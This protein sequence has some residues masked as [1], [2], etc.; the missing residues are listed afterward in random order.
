M[1]TNIRIRRAF[2][3]LIDYCNS[4]YYDNSAFCSDV[5][6]PYCFIAH[7]EGTDSKSGIKRICKQI[8]FILLT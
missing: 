7:M 5:E 4:I 8:L 1:K 6:C 2:I 3:N